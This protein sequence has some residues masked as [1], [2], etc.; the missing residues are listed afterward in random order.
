M[1]SQES[2][3][4]LVQTMPQ[5]VMKRIKVR[6]ELDSKERREKAKSQMARGGRS[7]PREASQEPYIDQ[8]HEIK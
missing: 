3:R 2:Q 1:S 7:L 6:N 5:S 8:C 4:N